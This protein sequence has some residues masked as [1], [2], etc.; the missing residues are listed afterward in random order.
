MR[1]KIVLIHEKPCPELCNPCRG[2]TADAHA[3]KPHVGDFSA[4]VLQN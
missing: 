4:R 3:L 2:C 1:S